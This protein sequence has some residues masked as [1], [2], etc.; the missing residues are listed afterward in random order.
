MDTVGN[1]YTLGR[2][3]ASGKHFAT[4]IA[5]AS[6]VACNRNSSNNLSQPLYLFNTTY[7]YISPY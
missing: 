2:S 4:M 5:T 6:R 1:R 3:K 7:C